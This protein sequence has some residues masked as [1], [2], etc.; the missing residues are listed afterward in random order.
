MPEE[1][2]IPTRKQRMKDALKLKKHREKK[3]KTAN[4]NITS[5]L[6]GAGKPVNVEKNFDPSADRG[7][8]TN[9]THTWMVE[10]PTEH[11]GNEQDGPLCGRKRDGGNIYVAPDEATCKRCVNVYKRSKKRN[12]KLPPIKSNIQPH[13]SGESNMHLKPV[14]EAAICHMFFSAKPSIKIRGTKT[15]LQTL[16]EA[17][18]AT[19]EFSKSLNENSDHSDI[20]T[21]LTHKRIAEAKFEA[22]FGFEWP[23]K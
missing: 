12:L 20:I 19:K 18:K 17:L 8:I 14:L 2:S 16:S 10:L 4:K 6:A 15:E 9:K 1:R 23:I 22:A 7:V 11:I 3:R 13:L 5:D 21:K